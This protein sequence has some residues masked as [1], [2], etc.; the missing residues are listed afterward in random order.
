M[1][2]PK[3]CSATAN[4]GGCCGREVL[5]LHPASGEGGAGAG[6]GSEKGA[7]VPRWRCPPAEDHGAKAHTLALAPTT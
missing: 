5:G 4:H 7:L 3:T 6:R 2:R 1:E